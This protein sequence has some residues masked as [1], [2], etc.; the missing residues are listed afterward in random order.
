MAAHFAPPLEISRDDYHDIFGSSDEKMDNEDSD[1]DVSEV[2]DKSDENDESGSNEPVEWTDRLPNIH[3]D[4]FTSPVGITLQ[5]G[6]ESRE[7]IS[8]ECFSMMKHSMSL[9]VK[10]TTMLGKN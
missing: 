3:V 1:I 6:N 4:Y 2:E 8:P 7:M 5:I 10:Q 9:Y